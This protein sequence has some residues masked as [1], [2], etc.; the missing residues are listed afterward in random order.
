MKHA[1]LGIALAALVHTVSAQS[2]WGNVPIGASPDEVKTRLPEV[3]ETSA[4]RRAQ[5]SGALLEIPRHEL[6]GQ[7]FAVSFVFEADKLQ[8]VVL[9]A[10]PESDEQAK[11]LT[12]DL[13][14]SLRK[15]YGLDV[16]TRSRR[17]EAREGIVDR[18]WLFR[19]MSVRLQ[20]LDDQTVR[21][22]YSAESPTPTPSRGL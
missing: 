12:R 6:A 11:A 10:D 13:G 2:L 7:A 8:S 20:L 14:D 15:R 22:T 17:S 1:I 3:Q 16:S 9:V 21:L 18:M 19:R 5:D 4:Q